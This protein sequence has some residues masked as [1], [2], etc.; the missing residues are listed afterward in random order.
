[1]IEVN[2]NKAFRVEKETKVPTMEDL[3]MTRILK[4]SDID[5]SKSKKL[6]GNVWQFFNLEGK[7]VGV[8]GVH[9]GWSI[10]IQQAI[11]ETVQL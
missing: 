2:S 1:L 3:D 5:F 7:S 8:S 9:E 11:E 4:R 10:E 6:S